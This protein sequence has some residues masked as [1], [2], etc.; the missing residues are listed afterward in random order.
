MLEEAERQVM[1]LALS[2]DQTGA[3]VLVDGMSVE[4]TP[5]GGAIRRDKRASPLPC[6]EGERQPVPSSWYFQGAPPV[7]LPLLFLATF[8][9]ASP[10]RIR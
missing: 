1:T 6:A 7:S 4:T 10:S 2:T 3:E 8:R 5:S 9:L